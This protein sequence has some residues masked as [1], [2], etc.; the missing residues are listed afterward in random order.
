VTKA[1][2]EAH[3]TSA[4]ET[5]RP[6]RRR[7]VTYQT[8]EDFRKDAEWLARQ[9]VDTAGRWSYGQI[10][11]HLAMSLNC[12]FDGFGY[13]ASWFSRRFVAPLIKNTMITRRMPAGIVLPPTAR[14]MIPE[15]IAVA[16]ALEN[17]R[18]ALSRLENET[19]QAA[20]PF[21]GRLASQE[22]VSLTLRHAELHMSFVVPRRSNDTDTLPEN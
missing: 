17:L 18:T 2:K 7:Q 11:Q 5:G 6:L 21:L 14:G 3:V 13:R 8:L 16:P 19:P 10:L 20:H 12:A 15:P 9:E 1:K 22:W 4:M